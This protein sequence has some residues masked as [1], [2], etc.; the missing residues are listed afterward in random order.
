[1]FNVLKLNIKAI[2]NINNS[3]KNSLILFELAKFIIEGSLIKLKIQITIK[4]EVNT[5]KLVDNKSS[6][7]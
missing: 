2:S 7:N 5:I 1:M 3:T 6:P 4:K